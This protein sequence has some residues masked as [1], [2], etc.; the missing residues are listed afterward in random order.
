MRAFMPFYVVGDVNLLQAR[1]PPNT[2]VK[3]N[4]DGLTRGEDAELGV[5]RY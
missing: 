5:S 2:G 4:K 1:Q 3:M